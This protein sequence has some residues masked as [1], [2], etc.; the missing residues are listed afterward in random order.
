MTQAVAKR[1]EAQVIEAG[2][3]G[4]V[5]AFLQVIERAA[6]DPSVDVEKMERLLA[7]QEKV[8]G[9]QAKAAFTA[10]LVD[11][12]PKLPVIERKGRIIIRDKNNEQ[13]IKQS[14][15]YALWEDIDELITPLLAEHGFALSFRS[16]VASDG[17]LTVTGIL[18]HRDGHSEET[19]MTLPHDSSGSKNAVQ[20][21][22]SSMSYGKRY[23]ATLLLNIRTKGED[24][25]G[26][27]AGGDAKIT[28]DQLRML[29]AACD[30]VGA[31]KIAFCKFLKVE[32]LAEL[33]L[34]RY[35]EAMKAL[36]QKRKKAA[37]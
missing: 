16:G 29:I 35:G 13:V 15:P 20:A 24:D 34:S 9:R 30:E 17:K 21:V 11:L 28:D 36:E 5:T 12:K 31:D 26:A 25:D 37:K 14:T 23:T 6:R 10:A 8:L 1:D 19:T 4:E 7:M 33:P 22:G 32:A 3:G 18:S 27:A 2:Q